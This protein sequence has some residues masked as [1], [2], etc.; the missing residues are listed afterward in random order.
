V[1]VGTVVENEKWKIKVY[2]PPK[3]HGNP[4]VH[5]IAKGENA[6]LKVYLEDYAI[7]EP[8]NFSKQ[9]VNKILKYIDSNYDE[10]MD[11]WEALHGKKKETK[12]K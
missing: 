2:G 9:S 5:V 6:E 7:V 3:E 8:T 4:H 1:K 11:A 12:S 10:L